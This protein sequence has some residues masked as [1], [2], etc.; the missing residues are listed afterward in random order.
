ML[1]TKTLQLGRGDASHR[2]GNGIVEVIRIAGSLGTGTGNLA[3]EL[4]HARGLLDVL[5]IALP[6]ELDGNHVVGLDRSMSG[7]G[8]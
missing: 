6:G 7:V 2:S 3:R 4:N 5:G 1:T 8:S